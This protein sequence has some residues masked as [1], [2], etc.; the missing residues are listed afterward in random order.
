MTPQSSRSSPRGEPA[1]RCLAG[2]Y[3]RAYK[4]SEAALAIADPA[5]MRAVVANAQATKAQTLFDQCR[6]TEAVALCMLALEIG[7]EAEL[8]DQALRAYNNLAYYR[9]QGGLPEQAVE[10]LDAGIELARS[11]ATGSGNAT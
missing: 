5:G 1:S 10:L 7:L 2:D 8:A 6:L 11:A 4:E 9:L 3:D